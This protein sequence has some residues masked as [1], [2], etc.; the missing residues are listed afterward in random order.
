MHLAVSRKEP[1]LL[2]LQVAYRKSTFQIT[3]LPNLYSPHI[4]VAKP[5]SCMI[6]DLCSQG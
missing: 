3:T 2:T 1:V 4:N 5:V 6:S